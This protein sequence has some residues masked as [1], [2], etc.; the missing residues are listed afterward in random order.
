MCVHTPLGRSATV[1]VPSFQF[2]VVVTR[3]C[4]RLLAGLN[5]RP[6][7]RSASAWPL[8]TSGRHPPVVP[9]GLTQKA[10]EKS[11][12]AA[13]QALSDAVAGATADCEPDEKYA[14][15]R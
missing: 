3:K 6:G 12:L 9:L 8:C 4:I 15:N 2:A 14:L 5:H 7:P 10:T 11:A 13:P 1:S